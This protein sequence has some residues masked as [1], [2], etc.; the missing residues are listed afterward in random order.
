MIYPK[1]K[2]SSTR[3]ATAATLFLCFSPSKSFAFIL[4]NS[5][6]VKTVLMRRQPLTVIFQNI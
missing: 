5:S 6:W 4:S 3:P 1:A 2:T